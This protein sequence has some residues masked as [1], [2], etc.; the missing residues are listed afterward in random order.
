MQVP[1]ILKFDKSERR[2]LAVLQVDEGDLAVLVKQV[3]HVLRPDVGR[4][5]PHVH[6]GLLAHACVRRKTNKTFLDFQPKLIFS[7]FPR[8]QQK[9]KVALFAADRFDEAQRPLVAP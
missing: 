4:K 2:A 6:P 1:G 5:V 3:F 8:N 7:R 9:L